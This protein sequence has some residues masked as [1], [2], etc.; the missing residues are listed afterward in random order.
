MRNVG[1]YI[2]IAQFQPCSISVQVAAELIGTATSE[3]DG[4]LSKYLHQR[5]GKQVSGFKSIYKISTTSIYKKGIALISIYGVNANSLYAINFGNVLNCKKIVGPFRK[6]Q[7]L[8]FY[9]D[10][11]CIYFENLINTIEVNCIAAS[12]DITI[13][14]TDV[15]ISTLTEI[16]IE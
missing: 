12:V 16:A 15:D 6:G 1:Y 5:I 7:H 14:A 8:N 9:K 11:S 4:L 2:I 13:E 3:K 10:D